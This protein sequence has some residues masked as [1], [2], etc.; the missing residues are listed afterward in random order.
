MSKGFTLVELLIV[1]AII[2]ILAG[3]ILF[4]LNP[5]R[6]FA[7][8]RN[9]QRWTATNSYL[10][11]ITQNQV[12]NN[13]V[14]TCSAGALPATATVMGSGAGQ[15]N[16]CSCLVPTFAT[17]LAFDPSAG[18]YI[19]CADYNTG[20]SVMYNAADGR[21]TIAAPNAE[22]GETVTLTQ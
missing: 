4:G 17:Q 11:I 16:I 20:Y 19:S 9:S 1:I 5:A 13:G 14:W 12:R 7:T 10:R 21:T 3:T 22:L 8:T 6:Q 15:Y 2:A 18:N